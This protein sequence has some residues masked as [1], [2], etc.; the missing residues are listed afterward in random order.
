MP[1][2]RHAAVRSHPSPDGRPLRLRQA[3]RAEPTPGLALRLVD[4]GTR[5]LVTYA[6]AA[7]AALA[8]LGISP[9][10]PPLF[11]LAA[12]FLVLAG[13]ALLAAV[14]RVHRRVRRALARQWPHLA[15]RLALSPG[16][17]SGRAAIP[18]LLFLAACVSVASVALEAAH[19]P[20]GVAGPAA[21]AFVFL[22]VSWGTAA[23]YDRAVRALYLARLQI[24]AEKEETQGAG[25]GP[26]D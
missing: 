11:P 1:A 15:G 16:P 12:V 14:G 10:G 23:R 6:L 21:C 22:M 25:Q 3:L 13:W 7:T 2:A 9:A 19:P 26:G 17:G 4:L 18:Y 20:R 8:I 24:A 5:L